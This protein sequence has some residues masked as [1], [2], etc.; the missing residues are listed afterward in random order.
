[1][2]VAPPLDEHR[3]ERGGTLLDV[4]QNGRIRCLSREA[5]RGGEQYREQGDSHGARNYRVVILSAAKVLGRAS[6]R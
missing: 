3:R 4:V 1:M 2:D 6:Q 5:K